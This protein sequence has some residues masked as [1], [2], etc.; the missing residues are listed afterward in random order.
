M[1]TRHHAVQTQVSVM[2]KMLKRVLASVL[3]LSFKCLPARVDYR[4]L[5]TW[6]GYA[7][8]LRSRERIAIVL[9]QRAG[10]GKE[11]R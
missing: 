11:R 8:V 3:V 10:R 9:C 1:E 7:R 6:G 4:S 2:T 5:V